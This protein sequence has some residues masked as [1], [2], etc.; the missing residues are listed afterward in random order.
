MRILF[1]INI[2][3][4]DLYKILVVHKLLYVFFIILKNVN[5]LLFSNWLNSNSDE[6]I[7]MFST[8]KLAVKPVF[9]VHMKKIDYDNIR[10]KLYA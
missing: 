10:H 3:L 8:A 7:F 5:F 2:V 1:R 6:K 4:L 9:A